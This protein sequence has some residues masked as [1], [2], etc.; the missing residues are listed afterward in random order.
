M[1]RGNRLA[2]VQIK[3]V[4]AGK[5]QAIKAKPNHCINSPKNECYL[6]SVY[7]KVY[8]KTINRE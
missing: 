7:T 4:V 8:Y 2:A 5:F 3:K 6:L 1:A